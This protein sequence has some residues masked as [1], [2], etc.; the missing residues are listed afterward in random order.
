M[1]APTGAFDHDI[2]ALIWGP[3]VAALSFVFDKTANEA[4]APKAIAGFRKCAM[5]SAHYGLS[6]VFDNL[7]ISLCKFT[8]LLSAVEVSWDEGE[9]EKSKKDERMR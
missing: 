9:R 3:T 5:I 6:D 2:F 8:T 7:V 1:H 4:V